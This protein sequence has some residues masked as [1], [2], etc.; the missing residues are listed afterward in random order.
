M[1]TNNIQPSIFTI[2]IVIGLWIGVGL[3]VGIGL[4]IGNNNDDGNKRCKHCYHSR[5]K[6]I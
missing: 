1:N 5:E 4:H 6:F 2:G 3:G